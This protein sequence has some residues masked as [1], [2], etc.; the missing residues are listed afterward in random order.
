MSRSRSSRGGKNPANQ[1]AAG[2]A[3]ATSTS[4]TNEYVDALLVRSTVRWSL[5]VAASIALY[6]VAVFAGYPY[7][8]A[9]DGTRVYIYVVTGIVLVLAGAFLTFLGYRMLTMRVIRQGRTLYVILLPAVMLLSV[10]ISILMLA[11]PT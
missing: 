11:A 8:A 5:V 1:R 2:P 9:I 6:A 10:A 3:T 4:A 7:P